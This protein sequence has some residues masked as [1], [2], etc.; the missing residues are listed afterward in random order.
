MYDL[1]NEVVIWTTLPYY[2]VAVSPHY[3]ASKHDYEIHKVQF[4]RYLDYLVKIYDKGALVPADAT[5]RPWAILVDLGY[6]GPAH[7]TLD[8]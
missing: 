2:C 7:H 3:P 1:K 8:V 5:H 6:I 4:H